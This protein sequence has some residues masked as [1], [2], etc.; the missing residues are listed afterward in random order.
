MKKTKNSWAR[1]L[2]GDHR[3]VTAI[4]YALLAS[5]LGIAIVAGVMT[6]GNGVSGTFNTVSNAFS[7]GTGST[8]PPAPLGSITNPYSQ[9][10]P[11]PGDLS[12][13]NYQPNVPCGSG[14]CNSYTN[15]QGQPYYILQLSQ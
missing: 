14:T 4:E 15:S 12:R 6:A 8:P 13:S 10:N 9:N 3:G 5:L 1:R 11:P 2:R 7:S